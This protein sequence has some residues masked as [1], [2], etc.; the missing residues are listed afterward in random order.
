MQKRRSVL[1]LTRFYLTIL[2]IAIAL[3]VA[4]NLKACTLELMGRA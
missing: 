1:E 4:G 2:K 3:A